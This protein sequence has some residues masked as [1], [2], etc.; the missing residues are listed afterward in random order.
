MSGSGIRRLRSRLGE[1]EDMFPGWL[2]E[3]VEGGVVLSPV[4]PIHPS[5]IQRLW[6]TLKGQLAPEWALVS[7][8]AFPFDDVNEFCPDLAVIPASAEAGN[9]SAYPVGPIEFVAEAVSPESIRRD[10]E[11]KPRWYASCSIA[12]H[13]VFDPL[14]G[15]AVTLWNPGPDGYQG[16]DTIPYGPE[17]TVESPL[18]KLTIPTDRLPVDP[19]VSGR[20]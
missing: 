15:H 19:Q 1:L 5:T 16:R 8:V 3:I 12:N 18:G 14:Q 6:V 17:L 10:Y 2:S 11:I 9:R 13:L 20:S 4:R 7:D